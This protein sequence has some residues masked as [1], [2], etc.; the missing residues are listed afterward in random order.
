MT[1]MIQ[2]KYPELSKYIAE[3]PES[4]PNKKLPEINS[5]ILKEYY[6]SLAVLVKNYSINHK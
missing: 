4:I 1:L 5:K 3:M 2:D 6:D